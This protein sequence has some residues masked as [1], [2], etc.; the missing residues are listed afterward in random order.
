MRWRC[1][2]EVVARVRARVKDSM[3]PRRSSACRS[4]S[5]RVA[6]TVERG[7]HG[8][9]GVGSGTGIGVATSDDRLHLK[10]ARRHARHRPAEH[11]VGFLDGGE[12]PT[13]TILIFQ[14]DKVTAV[15]VRVARRGRLKSSN[16]SRPST[17]AW[18]GSS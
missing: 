14:Q 7:D 3:A 13:G 15:V 6:L 18:P 8:P 4:N 5:P 17:S 11:D 12:I 16:A 9:V 1:S 10:R 2:D